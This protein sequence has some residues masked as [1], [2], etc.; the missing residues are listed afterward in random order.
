MDGGAIGQNIEQV[1]VGSDAEVKLL[2]EPCERPRALVPGC[3]C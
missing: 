2:H 1:R 3:A